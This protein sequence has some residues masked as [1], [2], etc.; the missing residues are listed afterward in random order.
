MVF[1]WVLMDLGYIAFS[2]IIITHVSKRQQTMFSVL[3]RKTNLLP[4]GWL[5]KDANHFYYFKI[6]SVFQSQQ[7]T[8]MR[9]ANKWLNGK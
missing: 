2:A 6:S 5:H 8:Y 3:C 1:S 7:C 9:G 4:T